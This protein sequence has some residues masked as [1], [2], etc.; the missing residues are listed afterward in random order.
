MNDMVCA[1]I[2]SLIDELYIKWG[3]DPVY[4]VDDTLEGKKAKIDAYIIEWLR[5]HLDD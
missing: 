2:Q 5:A 3:G 4:H 1:T